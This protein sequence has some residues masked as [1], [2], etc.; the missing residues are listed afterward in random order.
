[1]VPGAGRVHGPVKQDRPILRALA[2]G[3]ARAGDEPPIEK[4]GRGRDRERWVWPH[5]GA[6][7]GPPVPPNRRSVPW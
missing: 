7:N 2:E 4:P 5:R 1:M 6:G 3:D